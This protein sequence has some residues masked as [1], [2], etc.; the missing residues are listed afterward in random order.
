V[1]AMACM[2]GP[3]PTPHSL[4]LG[5]SSLDLGVVQL[6]RL[7]RMR[8]GG[9]GPGLLLPPGLF[10]PPSS[11]PAVRET[12]TSRLPFTTLVLSHSGMQAW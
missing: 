3:S 4:R 5:T 2:G 11:L 7:L 10:T 12:A 9:L 8:L 6:R 1:V